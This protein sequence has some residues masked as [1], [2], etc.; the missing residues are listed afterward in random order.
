MKR[1]LK[2]TGDGTFINSITSA[3]R[4]LR[5]AQSGGLSPGGKVEVA[6]HAMCPG[7]VA[8]NIAR[9]APVWLKPLVNPLLGQFF[10]P[11]EQAI[12]PVIYLCCAEAA[13]TATGMYLHMMQRKSVSTAAADPDNGVRLWEASKV[14]VEKSRAVP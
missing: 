5:Q 8:T 7:G 12:G 2:Q 11:P 1:K 13:G 14:L 3:I 9:D 10:Q 6:V 4:D